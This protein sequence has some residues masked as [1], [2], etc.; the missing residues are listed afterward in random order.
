MWLYKRTSSYLFAVLDIIFKLGG[1]SNSGF[2]ISAKVADQDVAQRYE[3]EKME[4]GVTSPMFIVLSSVAML[5][6]FC[7]YG[8]LNKMMVIGEFKSVY[9][10]MA[11]QSL[12]CGVLVLIN[13][14]MYNALLFRR[15]KGQDAKL[16]YC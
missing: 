13:L 11:L 6:L 10:T 5:N 16:C 14:P 8:M 2:I 7:L 1:Y 3:Q 4:F 9:K 15:D 12:L